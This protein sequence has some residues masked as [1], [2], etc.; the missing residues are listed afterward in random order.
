MKVKIVLVSVFMVVAFVGFVTVGPARAALDFID[1]AGTWFKVTV[2]ETGKAGPVVPVGGSVQTNNEK[3]STT[4]LFIDTWDLATTTYSVVYCTFNGTLWTRNTGLELPV[5]GGEPENFLT[6][7][8]V[9]YQETQAITETYWIPLLLT[10]KEVK[11]AVGE[12]KS[13]SFQNLG[14]IFYEEI[15][16]PVVTSKGVGSVKFKGK[17]ITPTKVSTDVPPLCKVP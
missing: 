3:S 10:G 7:F 16:S 6:F 17:F 12:I 13:A 14:G 15:G 11:N 5:Y 8:N 9:S 2:S 4:Y 1:W